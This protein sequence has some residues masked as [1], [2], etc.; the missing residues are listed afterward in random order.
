MWFWLAYVL[1]E[2]MPPENLSKNCTY[3]EAVRSSAAKRYGIKNEPNGRQLFV[4]KHLAVNLFQPVRD[5]F[6][7]KI[8]IS[9]FYRSE[10]V[11]A[12]IGGVA[13][14][15]HCVNADVAAI[16]LDNDVW[17]KETG[18]S[19][20][21]IFWYIFD[22]L[23]YYKLIWEFGDDNKPNW[24]HVSFSTDPKKNKRKLTYKAVRGHGRTSY[25][26]FKDNR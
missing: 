17:E 1:N 14:S 5:H 2:I 13:N 25:V 22:N 10:E 26:T 21:D 16:D 3:A 23:D 4:M 20:A 15:D 12:I 24:V 11:N 9:S 8:F 6:G 7:K 19:N 18:V